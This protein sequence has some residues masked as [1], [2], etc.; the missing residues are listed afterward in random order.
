MNEEAEVLTGIG[1]CVFLLP[2]LRS[3]SDLKSPESKQL[4]S[5]TLPRIPCPSFIVML[6]TPSF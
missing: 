4:A 3:F 2:Y 6:L 5:S 1:N